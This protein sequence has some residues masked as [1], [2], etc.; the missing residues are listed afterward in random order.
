MN[1]KMK[2]LQLTGGDGLAELEGSVGLH[3]GFGVQFSYLMRVS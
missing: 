2:S 3:V 1:I